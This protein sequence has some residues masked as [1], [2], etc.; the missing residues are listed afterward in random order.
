[1]ENSYTFEIHK[2]LYLFESKE[3]EEMKTKINL[4]AW[5]KFRR[6]ENVSR[7]ISISSDRIGKDLN[8]FWILWWKTREESYVL[9]VQLTPNP[10]RTHLSFMHGFGYS[11]FSIYIYRYAYLK[12][13][14]CSDYQSSV[15]VIT[16]ANNSHTD[17]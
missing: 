5:V 14:R 6:K 4:K 9:N 10:N 13:M 15:Y 2:N 7:K 1:M 11:N 3:K 16:G 17:I 12:Y 8:M